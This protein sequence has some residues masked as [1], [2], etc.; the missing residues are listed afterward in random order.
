MMMM[1]KFLDDYNCCSHGWERVGRKG[2]GWGIS[3]ELGAILP[4]VLGV[5]LSELREP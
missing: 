3:M 5:V 4:G 1:I 2:C